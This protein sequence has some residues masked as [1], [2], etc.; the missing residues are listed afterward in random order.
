MR[1]MIVNTTPQKKT[2][3]DIDY[4]MIDTNHEFWAIKNL[5]RRTAHLIVKIK[6]LCVIHLTFYFLDKTHKL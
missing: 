2:H 6:F 5:S 4:K 1:L 3:S